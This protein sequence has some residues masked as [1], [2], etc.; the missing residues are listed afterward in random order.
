MKILCKLDIQAIQSLKV[1][2]FAVS[3]QETKD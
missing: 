3:G 1:K 2:Y